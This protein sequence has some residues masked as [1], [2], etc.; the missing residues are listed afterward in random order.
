M[1]AR[2]SPHQHFKPESEAYQ[3]LIKMNFTS[4]SSQPCLAEINFTVLPSPDH[5]L[6]LVPTL[7]KYKYSGRM[8]Q[9]VVLHT[10]PQANF[11]ITSKMVQGIPALKKEK[12]QFWDIP[13]ELRLRCYRYAFLSDEA[14]LPTRK[15]TYLH[16]HK[17]RKKDCPGGQLRTSKA[18][19][20]EAGPV[21][22]GEDEFSFYDLSDDLIFIKQIGMTNACFLRYLRFNVPR[23]WRAEAHGKMVAVVADILSY[24]CP[25]LK[26]LA[27]DNVTPPKDLCKWSMKTLEELQD[28]IKATETL[29]IKKVHYSRRLDCLLLTSI[30]VLPDGPEDVGL[31]GS[32]F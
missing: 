8:F 18:F 1:N 7:S 29:A 3:V 32:L 28:V 9:H 17:F 23:Y 30:D 31:I 14:L 2:V 10:P 20:L 27:I 19:A 13:L 26:R 16:D 4:R 25:K 6:V 15:L 24:K 22:Y 5:T 11:T 21:V 12:K